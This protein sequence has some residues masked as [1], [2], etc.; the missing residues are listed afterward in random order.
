MEY[1]QQRPK[2]VD[3]DLARCSSTSHGT[4]VS[5]VVVADGRHR[6][7]LLTAATA[8]AATRT[9]TTAASSLLTS[10]SP[11]SASERRSKTHQD[12][13]DF[14]SGMTRER[15][16]QE[17]RDRQQYYFGVPPHSQVGSGFIS[18][19]AFY[20]G[21]VELSRRPDGGAARSGGS[22]RR[23]LREKKVDDEDD[24]PLPPPPLPPSPPIQ[25]DER[26]ADAEDEAGAMERMFREAMAVADRRQQQWRQQ[27]AGPPARTLWEQRREG[28]LVREVDDSRPCLSCR[29]GC[30]T[31]YKQHPWR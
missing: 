10:T 13:R 9:T 1:L 18:N 24:L 16:G 15:Q 21:V 29:D 7:S 20:N 22:G 23:A 25:E 26:H 14:V 30:P 27:P 17:R 5:P 11:T 19:G 4:Y 8:G 2:R 31:G 12:M 6:R 3:L 28:I